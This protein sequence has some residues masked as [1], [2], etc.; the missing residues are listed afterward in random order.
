M[1]CN[2]RMKKILFAKI[3]FAEKKNNVYEQNKS[4]M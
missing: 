1:Y 3:F 4:K 2:E